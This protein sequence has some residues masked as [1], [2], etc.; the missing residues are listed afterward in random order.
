[1]NCSVKYHL[2]SPFTSYAAV[3]PFV[4]GV[5]KYNSLPNILLSLTTL[6]GVTKSSGSFSVFIIILFST[7]HSQYLLNQI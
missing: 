1:M 4:A 5:T 7:K 6:V 2:T 3:Y